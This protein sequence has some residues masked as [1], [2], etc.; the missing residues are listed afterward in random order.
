MYL[1]LMGFLYGFIGPRAPKVRSATIKIIRKWRSNEKG[2]KKKKKK[3]KREL[4]L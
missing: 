2:N 1:G 4:S 3:K